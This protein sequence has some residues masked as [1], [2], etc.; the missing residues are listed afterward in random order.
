MPLTTVAPAKSGSSMDN[1]KNVAVAVA[2]GIGTGVVV[3]E[4]VLLAVG[5]AVGEVGVGVLVGVEVGVLVAVGV[6]VLVES[7]VGVLVG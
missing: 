7:R 6:G 1:S 5:V 3:D 2:S 4:R